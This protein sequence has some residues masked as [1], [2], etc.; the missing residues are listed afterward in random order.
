MKRTITLNY[1]V[2]TIPVSITGNECKLNCKH[3]GGFYLGSMKD[4]SNMTADDVRSMSVDCNQKSILV[5]G[6]CD[7]QGAVPLWEKMDLLHALKEAGFRLNIHTGLIPT[8]KIPLIAQISDMI[9]FDFITDDMTIREVYGS[10]KSDV[11]GQKSE[12][13]SQMPEV[14]CRVSGYGCEGIEKLRNSLLLNAIVSTTEITEISMFFL[15]LS[16]AVSAISALKSTFSPF[17]FRM[18]ISG[19]DYIKTYIALKKKTHVVPHIT[20]GILGGKIRGEYDA[21]DTIASLGCDRIVFLVFIP[22]RG[23]YYKNCTPPSL[24]DVRSVFCHARKVL[25]KGSFGIGCMHPRGKYKYNLEKLA[26]EY[27]FESYVNPSKKFRSFLDSL[28]HDKNEKIEIVIKKECCAF[29]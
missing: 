14:G 6:G 2:N 12:V 1:P 23:S 18:W 16:S 11:G 24:N 22:T 27:G 29:S 19:K 7:I 28:Q 10:R 4:W 25:P 8:E 5:S 26:F 20:I 15:R 9:S 3:C 21:I 17:S 13:R